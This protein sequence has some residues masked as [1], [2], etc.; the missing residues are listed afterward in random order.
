MVQ[1]KKKTVKVKVSDFEAEDAPDNEQIKVRAYYGERETTLIKVLEGRFELL[2]KSGDYLF[3]GLIVIILLLLFL[4]FWK[5]RK[6][7]EGEKPS[8]SVAPVVHH[9]QHH[10]AHTAPQHPA[11]QQVQYPAQQT[12]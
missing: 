4:L 1:A 12:K 5:R 10:F 7:K 9:A 2:I 3:Y 8:P 11:H 6:K